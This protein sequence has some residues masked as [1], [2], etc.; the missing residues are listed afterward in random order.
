MKLAKG[1][2]FSGHWVSQ[3]NKPLV[4][5]VSSGTGPLHMPSA[6]LCAGF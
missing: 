4:L 6:L 5:V 1:E 3:V 2:P